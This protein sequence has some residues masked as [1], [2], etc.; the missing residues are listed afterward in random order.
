MSRQTWITEVY[1]AAKII[2]SALLQD[3]RRILL[4]TINL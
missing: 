3:V 2:S 1:L 4:N